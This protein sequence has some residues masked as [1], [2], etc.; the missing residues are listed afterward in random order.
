MRFH[1][2]SPPW[3][4]FVGIEQAEDR[5]DPAAAPPNG[6][7]CGTP[8]AGQPRH[9]SLRASLIMLV[10]RLHPAR[11]GDLLLPGICQL[12]A[13]K[14][15]NRQ[16]DRG[17]GWANPRRTRPRTGRDGT[18]LHVLA[19]SELLRNGDLR[20]FHQIAEAALASQTA[21]NYVLIDRQGRQVLNTLRP[22]DAPP[23][24]KRQ[25]APTR[26]H[27]DT[28][29][30]VLTDLFRGPLTRELLLAMGFPVHD[31]EGRVIYT[32]NVGSNPPVERTTPAPA[33]ARQLAGRDHRRLGH[34]HRPLA[35]C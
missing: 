27:F 17:T 29:Q 35:R 9:I 3:G 13:R 5:P 22:V 8:A 2:R 4:I 11:P 34:H 7:G 32:L 20:R 6:A 14:S 31:K 15:K 10:S 21:Y 23:A 26:G 30:T 16:P 25:S 24:G 12:P 33:G 19:T 18:G 1:R 28:G